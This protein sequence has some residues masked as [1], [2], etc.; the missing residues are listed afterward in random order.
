M[1]III[2]NHFVIC[3]ILHT[4]PTASQSLKFLFS[5][6]VVLS[7]L[8]TTQYFDSYCI[9][10]VWYYSYIQRQRCL[11]I[12]VKWMQPRYV[13]M[14][15]SL[16]ES[17]STLA[18]NRESNPGYDLLKPSSFKIQESFCK[19]R[20]NRDVLRRRNNNR[21]LRIILFCWTLCTELSYCMDGNQ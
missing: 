6:I 14:V 4:G 8:F 12:H 20:L 17:R 15:K 9:D 16:F 21:R 18:A 5:K 10:S 19:L 11:I 1:L 3:T 7:S 2:N 13:I